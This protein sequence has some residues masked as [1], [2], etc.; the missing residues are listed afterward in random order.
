[1]INFKCHTPVNSFNE[2]ITLRSENGSWILYADEKIKL[3]LDGYATDSIELKEN[4]FFE[5][6]FAEIEDIL[7]V[8]I[9]S[10]SFEYQAYV[11]FNMT[12]LY[13]GSGNDCTIRIQGARERSV[14]LQKNQNSWFAIKAAEEYTS[15][16]NSQYY[17]ASKLT[18]G[19][20]I[21]VEGV[22]IIYMGENL[23]V[24][25]K[26]RDIHVNLPLFDYGKT[27]TS[28]TEV[29]P[30]SEVEKN[31]KLFT[32]DQVFVH[33]PRLKNEIEFEKIEVEEP[34]AK[35]LEQRTPAI[36]TI[37][38]SAVLFLASGTSIIQSI[39]NFHSGNSSFL[40]LFLEIVVFGL[41]FVSSIFLPMLLNKWETTMTEKREKLKQEKY[42]NYLIDKSNYIVN[43]LKK[44]EEILRLNRS[45][46]IWGREIV[47]SDFLELTIGVG[48]IP[49]KIEIH[50]PN[51]KFTID[52]DNLVE[53]VQRI[54][55]TKLELEN[56]PV[57]I[58]LTENIIMPLVINSTFREDYIKGIMLQLIYNYSGK[59]L[60]L[61]IGIVIILKDILLVMKMKY[62]NYLWN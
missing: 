2:S 6:K 35:E 51:K 49:A 34:P 4:I 47:D 11:M 1:M 39:S 23:L 28:N 54:S 55:D 56:V 31:Y 50:A 17:K 59:D 42:K 20:V 7:P 27:G 19:D 43:L 15:F 48:N 60:K 32:D 41:T 33:S 36:F 9:L 57:S 53:M 8:Y 38:S 37:G 12:E 21:F 13:I 52:D 40:A 62:N 61:V 29:T 24:E 30:V 58:S 46:E 18:N 26:I 16:I 14:V 10:N 44:Q 22:K 25:S 5:I 45:S 3:R